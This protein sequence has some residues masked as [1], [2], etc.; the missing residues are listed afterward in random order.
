METKENLKK[1]VEDFI[2]AMNAWE[3]QCNEIEEEDLDFE[4]EYNKQKQLVEKIFTEFCTTKERKQSRPNIISYGSEGSY[5]YDPFEE[6]IISI[7]QNEKDRVIVSTYREKP[8]QE[9][10]Q[11]IILCKN[12]KWLIDG[13]KRFSSWKNKWLNASL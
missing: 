2:V 1:H 9:K 4:E 12:N 11:Y 3:K 7:E 13:K 5:E 6:V 8:M 10:M